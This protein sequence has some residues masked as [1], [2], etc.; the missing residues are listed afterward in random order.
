MIVMYG[1]FSV[2]TKLKKSQ[3]IA[4]KVLEV[5]IPLKLL[6]SLTS[7]LGYAYKSCL[8]LTSAKITILTSMSPIAFRLSVPTHMPF[9]RRVKKWVYGQ[10]KLALV[11]LLCATMSLM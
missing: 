5:K 6:E 8:P 7:H 11:T 2:M 1:N 4:T 10:L 9:T 3:C